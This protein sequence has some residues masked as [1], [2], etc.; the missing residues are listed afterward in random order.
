MHERGGES[1]ALRSRALEYFERGFH[2]FIR[3]EQLHACC[4]AFHRYAYTN[5]DG[6]YA[7]GIQRDLCEIGIESRR[8]RLDDFHDDCSAVGK[9]RLSR[10][11]HRANRRDADPGD[12]PMSSTTPANGLRS[13]GQ[14]LLDDDIDRYHGMNILALTRFVQLPKSP[15]RAGIVSR[16]R[17]LGQTNTK[18]SSTSGRA[19]GHADVTP[20]VTIIR[21]S[22]IAKS[23]SAIHGAIGRSDSTM[24]GPMRRRSNEFHG[25]HRISGVGG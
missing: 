9:R 24:P 23:R 17:A 14:N 19:L 11:W 6:G 20:T 4:P 1:G 8:V 12:V 3:D 2:V 13:V 21:A 15:R 7:G 18:V 22:G 5:D 10:A 25:D 16:R